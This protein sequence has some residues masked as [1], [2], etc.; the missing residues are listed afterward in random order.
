VLNL[1]LLADAKRACPTRVANPVGNGNQF[2]HGLANLTDKTYTASALSFL[3]YALDPGL[4]SP[5]GFFVSKANQIGRVGGHWGNRGE[6]PR[7]PVPAPG[8]GCLGALARQL[9]I[10]SP[11]PCALEVMATRRLIG[12]PESSPEERELAALTDVIEARQHQRW[13]R[14]LRS[15]RLGISIAMASSSITYWP[16]RRSTRLAARAGLRALSLLQSTGAQN[17]PA[18]LYASDYCTIFPTALSAVSNSYTKP[19]A[20]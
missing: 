20:S 8:P 9:A 7:L 19:S 5:L 14:A 15:Q 4:L 16:R 18:C 17:C 3:A 11:L 10:V 13:R 1:I 2:D 12:C 6:G